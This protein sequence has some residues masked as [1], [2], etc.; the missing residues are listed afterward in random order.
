MSTNLNNKT[1]HSFFMNL[2]LNQAKLNLGNTGLNPSVGCVIVK[3]K[4]IIGIGSTGYG[5][6]PHAELNAIKNSYL[7]PSNSDMYITLEPCAHFGKTHPCIN[8][9][10]NAKISRV[11]FS[12]NDPD[13]RTFLK[14]K[15]ILQKKGIKVHVGLLKKDISEFYRSYFYNKYNNL[16]FVTGKLAI[17]KDFYSKNK[18]NKWITND[19]SRGRGHILRFRH[20]AIITSVKTVI[21]DNPRLNCRID[22]LNKFSP[23]KF[24]L[25]YDLKIPITSKIVKNAL[26]EKTYIIYNKI[27][28]KKLYLLKKKGLKTIY[29]SDYYK[30]RKKLIYILKK[31]F[32]LGYSRILIESGLTLL[33]AFLRDKLINDF[34]LFT[35]NNKA[36]SSGVN[37]SK[38]LIKNILKFKKK[39]YS[40]NINLNGDTIKIFK[41][42]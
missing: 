18:K 9:I 10:V 29:I 17:S 32:Q 3:N 38:K 33:D 13:E 35:S 15:M 34:Y 6:R 1:R 2:A 4:E 22:G 26:S 19:L 42:I 5:G 41:I 28:K 11:F 7:N 14:S 23:I 12:V 20:D 24:I 37:S 39:L 8:H 16:P 25:D 27:I 21:D 30:E 36:N 31:I 40:K